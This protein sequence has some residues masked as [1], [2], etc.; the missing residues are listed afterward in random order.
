[1][2]KTFAIW[3]DSICLSGFIFLLSSCAPT[4]VKIP[5]KLY[6][7]EIK[8]M[9]FQPEELTLQKGDTVVWINRDIVAHDATE[10]KG[11]N[12]TSG[13]LASGE[14]WSLVVTENADYFCSIHVVM[15]GKLLVQKLQP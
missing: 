14:S 3:K 7:V 5:N 12:W 6:T 11:R 15:K 1:M 9:K 8:E 13:P 2:S 10:E 4:E